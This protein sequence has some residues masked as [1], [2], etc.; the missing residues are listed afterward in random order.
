[1][2][3]AE[4]ISELVTPERALQAFKKAKEFWVKMKDLPLAE[5][6]EG[7]G[8]DWDQVTK[9]V[10]DYGVKLPFVY[11]KEDQKRDKTRAVRMEEAM[12]LLQEFENEIVHTFVLSPTKVAAGLIGG[13]EMLIANSASAI[14][15]IIEGLN[16]PNRDTVGSYWK[17]IVQ[18]FTDALAPILL[19]AQATKIKKLFKTR[20]DPIE[21]A[22][23][24]SSG[25]RT[26]KKGRTRIAHQLR[27]ARR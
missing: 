3:T 9:T 1:M 7:A 17:L 25:T 5:T 15:T 8:I 12:K 11:S 26:R 23:P 19:G 13:T 10:E 27:A 6:V 2:A 14:I 16:D 4:I 20:P 24:Q 18:L 21:K 22:L